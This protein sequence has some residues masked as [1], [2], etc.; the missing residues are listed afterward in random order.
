ML[1]KNN[2]H[3][4]RIR[5]RMVKLSASA[6]NNMKK[7][8]QETRKVDRRKTKYGSKKKKSSILKCQ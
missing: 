6:N 2:L 4:S 1:K 5:K 3:T 8:A 7:G